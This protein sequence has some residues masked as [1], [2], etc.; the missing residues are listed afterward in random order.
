MYVCVCVCVCVCRKHFDKCDKGLEGS[1]GKD[2]AETVVLSMTNG[3]VLVE[4]II[5]IID[6]II[7]ISYP[8]FILVSDYHALFICGQRAKPKG[9][10]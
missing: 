9:L 10:E 2:G 7:I 1:I 6:M 4:I 8:L 5:I 3:V